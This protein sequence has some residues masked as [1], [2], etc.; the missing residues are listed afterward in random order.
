MNKCFEILNKYDIPSYNLNK[1]DR[2]KTLYTYSSVKSTKQYIASFDLDWTLVRPK[3]FFPKSPED[4]YILPNR[5]DTLK[6]LVKNSWTI[7]IFTNQLIGKRKYDDILYLNNVNKYLDNLGIKH[8]LLAS[9]R[10]DKYRKPDIGMWTH[11]FD[12]V[13]NI[14]LGFFVGDASGR[15]KTLA[16]QIKSSQVTLIK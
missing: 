10:K 5:I 8:I 16:I 13:K 15:P 7:V 2:G 14:K 3:G 11:L 12:Y 4:F 6:M 1:I 9:L